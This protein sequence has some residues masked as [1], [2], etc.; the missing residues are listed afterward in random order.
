MTKQK[1][2]PQVPRLR[3]ALTLTAPLRMTAVW[4]GVCGTRERVPFRWRK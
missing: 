4:G 2:Q 1:R 3:G